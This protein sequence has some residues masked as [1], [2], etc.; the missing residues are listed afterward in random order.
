MVRKLDCRGHRPG[1]FARA[2][3]SG[4]R[5]RSERKS[6]GI[7]KDRLSRTRLA[8]EHPEPGLEFELDMFDEHDI[9]DR[10]LP[11]HAPPLNEPGSADP[12]RLHMLQITGRWACRPA[13]SCLPSDLGERAS[14]PWLAQTQ[15]RRAWAPTPSTFRCGAAPSEAVAATVGTSM[16]QHNCVRGQQK[17]STPRPG[18]RAHGSITPAP[19]ALRA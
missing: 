1:L 6:E 3:E 9:A 18:S 19:R 2:D 13:G 11:Q 10:K 4:V 14:R 5:P 15:R 7:E 17:P 12:L 8:S 16:S